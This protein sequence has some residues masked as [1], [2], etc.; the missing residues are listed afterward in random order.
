VAGVRFSLAPFVKAQLMTEFLMLVSGAYPIQVAV[1]SI[2][3]LKEW[4]FEG[5]A[6]FFIALTRFSRAG[7]SL[8]FQSFTQLFPF[9]G[10]SWRC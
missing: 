7:S 1:L 6:A 9:S 3:R 4:S 10:M 5:D 8:F 2:K